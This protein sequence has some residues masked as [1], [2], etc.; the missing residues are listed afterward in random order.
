MEKKNNKL[1]LSTE[2]T[3]QLIDHRLMHSP[4]SCNGCGKPNPKY[5]DVEFQLYVCGEDS[6]KPY[7]IA[8][9]IAHHAMTGE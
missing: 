8:K 5:F 9:S 1:I 7:D 2:V 3:P 4:K 6:C